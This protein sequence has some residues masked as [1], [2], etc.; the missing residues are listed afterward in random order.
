MLTSTTSS[1]IRL[2]SVASEMF[3]MVKTGGLGDVVASLPQALRAENVSVYTMLPGYPAV[4]SALRN[5][6]RVGV[7]PD[8]LGYEATIWQG[9]VGDNAL[10]VADIPALF[11]RQGNPY[12]TTDGVDWA[13][14]GIRFAAFCRAAAWVAQGWLEDFKPDVVQTHDWQAGLTA[15]FLHYD[16]AQNPK[17]VHTIHNI[18]FQGR[19]PMTE[20]AR[21]GLPPHAAAVDG[22]EYYGEIG[23]MKAALHFA[24]RITTV[25]P[26]YAQEIQTGEWG[27]GLEGLLR[28][29]AAALSG[30]LNGVDTQEWNPAHDRDVLFPY[31]V[32]DTF[33]RRPN[34]RAFQAQFGL[35]QNPSAFLLGM[36]SRLTTQKGV[37]LVADMAE[38]ILDDQTQLVVVG[39]GDRAIER[40]LV[41][42]Q[43]AFPGKF[44]CHIGFSEHL[45]HR[46]QASVD[47]LLIPSRFEPCGLTQLYAFRYGCVPIAARVGGLADTIIDANQAAIM[48]GAGTGFLFSPVNS[49]TLTDAVIRA[50]NVYRDRPSWYQLQQN[51]ANYDVSWG[52]KAVSYA[53]IFHDV[54]G[55]SV[56]D[57]SGIDFESFEIAQ[58]RRDAARKNRRIAKGGV[59]EDQV[60]VP[61]RRIA[62]RPLSSSPGANR[63]TH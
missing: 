40:R 23:F 39:S 53:R 55:T 11:Q 35:P 36:V 60:V 50:R 10:I 6:R 9:D 57:T 48:R 5:A 44:A 16:G 1:P 31:D 38:R 32:G 24:A 58:F 25:S 14:N 51:G 20:L 19:F 56:G 7:M 62:R 52:S 15:A 21:F 30:I 46:I 37:D 29:R 45:G 4:L 13:D 63:V 33:S 18:A 12:V 47:A 8:V 42:V 61:N 3:P 34:K 26:T 17:V 54:L 2:L 41:A 22:V 59:R 27:M 49:D 28:S 43:R